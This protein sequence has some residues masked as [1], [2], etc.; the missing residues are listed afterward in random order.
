MPLI[1]CEH[2][3]VIRFVLLFLS[4]LLSSL[5]RENRSGLYSDLSAKYANCL[6]RKESFIVSISSFEK[7][8]Y[9]T[10]V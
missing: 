6:E 5:P 2:C 8:H 7:M 4:F 9:V 1:S 10:F 3:T